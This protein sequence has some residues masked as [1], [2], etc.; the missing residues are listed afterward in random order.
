MSKKLLT[1]EDVKQIVELYK[2][3][4]NSTHKLAELYK[5]SHKRVSSILKQ[6]GVVVNKRGGQLKYGQE[7]V[8][9]KKLDKQR[10]DNLTIVA[11][12]KKTGKE[13][14]DYTNNSGS[15]SKHLVKIYPHIEIPTSFKAIMH[16]NTNNQYWYEKYFDLIDKSISP[17]RKCDFCEWETLDID[18]RTGCYENHLTS[19][20]KI[21][22]E[23]KMELNRKDSRLFINFKRKYDRYEDL[24][25]EDNFTICKICGDKMKQINNQHLNKKHNITVNEYKEKYGSDSL[26]SKRTQILLNE[27]LKEMGKLIKFSNTSKPELELS[28]FLTTLGVEHTRNNRNIIKNN[29]EIDIFIPKLNL[30]IEY[31]GILWHSENFGKKSF[32]YHLNKTIEM[33]E[34]GYKLIH[35]FEDEWVYKKDIVLNK[36]KYLTGNFN[37]SKIR[38]SSCNIE[39]IDSRLKND[40]LNRFHIQGEDKSTVCYGAYWNN[41]LVG[42]MTFMKSRGVN[43]ITNQINTFELSRFTTNYNFSIMGLG[44]KMLKHF[45]NEHNPYRVISFAD[46]RWTLDSKNNLYTKMGFNLVN[47]SPPNYFYFGSDLRRH[48]KFNFIKNKILKKFPELDKSLTESELM[49]ELGYDRIWD[50]GLYKYELIIPN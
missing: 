49:N 34:L 2:T 45:I 30:G 1:D 21:T 3:T 26:I 44:N 18:N 8:Y 47:T 25:D 50:C 35:V 28:E 36:I 33:N 46:I 23:Q 27:N 10:K 38:A 42:V 29:K 5:I 19:V 20:H 37:G 22:D 17:H 14:N 6:N 16:Y 7:M 39:Q 41:T 11:V 43:K 24:N 40:F 12:C 9:K 15:L 32:N 48:H 13:F 4:V 31:D